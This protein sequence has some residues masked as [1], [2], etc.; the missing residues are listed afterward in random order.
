VGAE[1]GVDVVVVL[2][3]VLVVG[4]R[5]EDRI[6]VDDVRADGVLDV[7]QLLVDAGK[8][9]AEEHRGVAA[10]DVGGDAAA[11]GVLLGGAAGIGVLAV[12]DVVETVGEDLVHHAVLHPVWRGE[13]GDDEEVAG[14]RLA[15]GDAGGVVP[16]GGRAVVDLDAVVLLRAAGRDG[17]L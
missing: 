7:A 16:G 15:G 10:A 13:A 8:V 4:W 2:R 17:A 3:V 11:P 9:A 6:E 12:G 1:G 5:G 14:R